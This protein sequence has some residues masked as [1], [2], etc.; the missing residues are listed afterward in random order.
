MEII[1]L[2]VGLL[3][4]NCYILAA[5]EQAVVIDPGGDAQKIIAELKKQQLQV[6]YIFNTHGHYD[7]VLANGEITAFTGKNIYI[8]PED[9]AMIEKDCGTLPLSDNQEFDFANSK[10]LVVHTPGHT[11]G[12]VSFLI[13]GNLFCGDLLFKQSVGRTDFLE[14]SP[15]DMAESLKK[16]AKL[17]LQTNVYPGHGP[18]TTIG[19]EKENNP[20]L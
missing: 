5:D 9:E 18:K 7:H 15:K 2:P 11:L 13:D 3:E 10:I 1:T 12:S 4:T 14:S 20:Y 8:H 17:D 6:Q 19:Y 16:I